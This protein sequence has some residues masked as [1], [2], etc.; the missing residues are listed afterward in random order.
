MWANKPLEF[1]ITCSNRGLLNKWKEFWK[2]EVPN[3]GLGRGHLSLF[4]LSG[5]PF[6]TALTA[7]VQWIFL[8]SSV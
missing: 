8:P 5:A 2:L 6:Y 4:Q 3:Q 7:L 1:K